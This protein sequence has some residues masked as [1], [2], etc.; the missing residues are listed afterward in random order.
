MSEEDI[1]EVADVS[2]VMD[3]CKPYA[4]IEEVTRQQCLELV[5]SPERIQAKNAIEA[6]RYICEAKHSMPN[7]KR[8][9]NLISIFKKLYFSQII[10]IIYESFFLKQHLLFA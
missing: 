9:Y 3:N 5:P 1:N 4:F 2:R 7:V 6:Y 8:I 10:N